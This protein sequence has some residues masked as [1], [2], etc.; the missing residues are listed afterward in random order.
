MKASVWNRKIH[1]MGAILIAV[2]LLIVIVSGILLLLKK[3]VAWIQPPTQRGVGT[4][5]TISFERV[6][7]AARGVE[8]ARI[9]S[10]DD[11]DRL[12]VRPGKGV[13][14]V[15]AKS[16]WEVQ[17]NT[18]TGDVL[19]VAYR[20]SDWI[21]SIHDGSFFHRLAKLWLFL[22]SAV[23]LLGLWGTGMYLFFLPRL[24]KRRNR[25]RREAAS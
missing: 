7:E 22:P 6:L 21:E 17:V 14:K 9:E 23:V 3:D 24:A 1:R 15:R 5:P 20:R 19:H 11:V 12:D 13:V 2:P 4:S 8:E 25:R 18:E 16:S 10:W